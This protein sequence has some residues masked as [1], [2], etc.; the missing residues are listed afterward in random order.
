[1]WLKENYK[2][3]HIQKFSNKKQNKNFLKLKDP[4]FKKRGRGHTLFVMTHW[5]KHNLV[6]VPIEEFFA[7][8]EPVINLFRSN[9]SG[10]Q[11]DCMI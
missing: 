3:M 10:F 8:E 7:T 2:L 11:P 9:V 4:V 6:G 1:M 5:K